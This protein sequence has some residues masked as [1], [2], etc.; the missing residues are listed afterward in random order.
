[1]VDFCPLGES[2][3]LLAIRYALGYNSFR[4][5]VASPA[6]FR[7]DDVPNRN[8]SKTSLLSSLDYSLG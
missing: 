6:S 2:L 8:C 7:A 4:F 1:V 5:D 3:S